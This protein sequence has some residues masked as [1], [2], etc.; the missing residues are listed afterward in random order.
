M[1]SKIAITGG[2]GAGKSVVQSI[3]KALGH[4]VYDCDLRAKMLMDSDIRILNAIGERVCP[5]AVTGDSLD[6]KKLAE[7]V[8]NDK[9]ALAVLNEIVHKE[10][11]R[12][13]REW[14][15]TR[16]PAFVETAILCTSG[17]DREVDEIWEVTAPEAVRVERVKKRN[18][19]LTESQILSR[20]EA[21]RD[22]QEVLS[23]VPTKKIPNDGLTPILPR[24][25]ELLA[26]ICQ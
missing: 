21:Q 10:V 22:E 25:E 5:E 19:G 16:V 15:A 14:S 1:I 7:R 4:E 23:G 3:L 26:S 6:R 17:L 11:V 13:F 2:I 12:D 18:P 20:I 8:F 24:I 9:V